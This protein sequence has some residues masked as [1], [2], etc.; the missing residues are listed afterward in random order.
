MLMFIKEAENITYGKVTLGIIRRGRHEHYEIKK[1]IT[2]IKEGLELSEKLDNSNK[3]E[4][5]NM[6]EYFSGHKNEK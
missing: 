2:M 5:E 3:K 1:H 6:V 4:F